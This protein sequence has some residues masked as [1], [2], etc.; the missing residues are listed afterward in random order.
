M[1]IIIGVEAVPHSG[2]AGGVHVIDIAAVMVDPACREV[3][4]FESLVRPDEAVLAALKKETLE[5]TGL[6]PDELRA[7]PG[8]ADAAERL[9]TFINANQ[10]AAFVAYNVQRARRLLR[11]KPWGL[12]NPW[13]CSIRER[14]IDSLACE[15]AAPDLKLYE[16]ALFLKIPVPIKRRALSSARLGMEIL[17]KMERETHNIS[18]ANFLREAEYTMEEGL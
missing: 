8:P 11:D 13:N 9:R 17:G 5:M 16:A 1:Y 6:T 15:D 3:A 18:D 10:G 2:I 12:S 14:V 7:A 4:A